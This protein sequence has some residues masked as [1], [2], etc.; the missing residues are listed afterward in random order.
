MTPGQ[1]LLLADGTVE[2]KV[3]SVSPPD[4]FCRV[5]LGGPLTSR[6]GVSVIGGPSGLRAFTARDQELLLSGIE[7]GVDLV[8]L[9]FVRAPVDIQSARSFLAARQSNLS[10]MAKIEKLESLDTID[11]ILAVADSIMVARGDLGIEVPIAQVPHIQ[12]ELI[13]KANEAAK[14]V[15]TA[16]QML[17]SMVENPRPT[18]AEVADVF[19][20][21]LDGSDAVMLSE[22]S[23]V[24]AYPVEA[25]KVLAETAQAAEARI[26][27]M[28]P[29]ASISDAGRASASEGIAR[30]AYLVALQTGAAA[31]FAARGEAGRPGS[32]RNTDQS[33]RLSLSHLTLDRAATHDCP[34]CAAHPLRRIHIDRCDVK[35]SN[36]T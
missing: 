22:E 21:V 13:A 10:V 3:E 12:K 35:R 2:L 24:G 36:Q 25:V 6:K 1:S 11:E 16:T 15:V 26:F 14:P 29:A 20:A 30:A 17:R 33:S 4:I 23:A 27:N 28:R 32:S 5:I 7:A 31:L 9:S 18:R 8:A 19:N 34:G